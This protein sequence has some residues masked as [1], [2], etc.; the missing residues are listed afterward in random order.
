[1]KGFTGGGSS[2]HLVSVAAYSVSNRSLKSNLRKET[3]SYERFG[4]GFHTVCRV[5][6]SLGFPSAEMFL[7]DKAGRLAHANAR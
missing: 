1:M 4:G 6:K 7:Y 5:M 2:R 3:L